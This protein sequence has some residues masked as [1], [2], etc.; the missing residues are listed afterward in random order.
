MPDSKSVLVTRPNFDQATAYL[1]AWAELIV[2]EAKDKNLKVAYLQGREASRKFFEKRVENNDP[3]LI[4][5]NGHGDADRIMGDRDEVLVKA[6]ENEEILKSRIVN[7]ISCNSAKELGPKSIEA[8]AKAFVGFCEN[9]IFL[10][11]DNHSATP[12]KD[13]TAEHFLSAANA[14]P[15]SL[16]KGNSIREAYEKSQAAFGRSIEYF[17][18]HYTPGNSH[19]LFCLKYDKKAQK[20]FGDGNATLSSCQC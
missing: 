18:T 11:E 20:F 3:A 8:G 5:F 6:G 19:I 12:R 7:S 9:F 4:A 2:E 15:I 14:V 17:T 13:K 16:I 10:Q 1:D